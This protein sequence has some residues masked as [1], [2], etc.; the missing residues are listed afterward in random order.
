MNKLSFFKKRKGLQFLFLSL[1]IIFTYSCKK[2]SSIDTADTELPKSESSIKSTADLKVVNGT[3]VFKDFASFTATLKYLNT[4]D[5]AKKDEWE[6]QNNFISFRTKY[7][8]LSDDLIAMEGNEDIGQ[9]LQKEK[10]FLFIENDEIKSK[11]KNSYFES[12]INTKGI[13]IIGNDYYRFY[14][15]EETIV[16]DGTEAKVIEVSNNK[17]FKS[18]AGVVKISLKAGSGDNSVSGVYCG[19]AIL[20]ECTSYAT[21]RKGFHRIQFSNYVGIVRDPFTYLPIGYR[22]EATVMLH[23]SAQKKIIGTWHS[24]ST[25]Y[26]CSTLSYSDDAGNNIAATDLGSNGD[27]RDWYYILSFYADELPYGPFPAALCSP[28]ILSFNCTAASGG[29]W[30]NFCNFSL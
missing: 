5:D 2:S 30:P 26:L 14:D 28:N 21:R 29:T 16:A 23:F 12:I 9:F 4:L 13:V 1:V 20:S 18:E 22:R 7:N 27:Y 17:N 11:V 6:M 15:N 19:G 25:S 24:Y 8:K 10:D 3:L